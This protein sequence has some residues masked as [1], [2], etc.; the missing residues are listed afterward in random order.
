MR[1]FA[2]FI[3]FSVTVNSALSQESASTTGDE[4]ETFRLV[5]QGDASAGQI[6]TFDKSV[7]D[8]EGSPFLYEQWLLG[9]VFTKSGGKFED[10]ELKYN[11]YRDFLTYRKKGQE[12]VL[13]PDRV[14]AFDL[15]VTP[16][17]K[18]LRFERRVY[19]GENPRYY[20]IVFDGQSVDLLQMYSKKFLKGR[21]NTD[22]YSAGR[23]DD[24]FID[25][26]DLLLARQGKLER[27]KKSRRGVLKKAG[28]HRKE[29]QRFVKQNELSYKKTSDLVIILAHF[30]MLMSKN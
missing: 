26:S 16:V 13:S 4:L 6:L 29:L 5:N 8:V 20:Q 14:A 9:S 25:D 30:D 18:P 22:G 2:T 1:L 3:L 17:S 21:A 27:F 23:N 7:R 24:R 10:V 28:A 15:K 12:Y 19:E 11:V